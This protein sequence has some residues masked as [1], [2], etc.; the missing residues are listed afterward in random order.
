MD[1]QYSDFFRVCQDYS[2]V[3]KSKNSTSVELLFLQFLS[4]YVKT[5]NSKQF[6]VSIQTRMPVVKTDK[7]WHSRKLLVEDPTDIKRS[8]CQT[9]QSPRSSDYFRDVFNAA[10]NYFARQQKPRKPKVD[11]TVS[12]PADE[13]FIEIVTDEPKHEPKNS[14]HNSYRLFYKRLPASVARE[15]TIKQIRVRDHYKQTFDEKDNPLPQGVLRIDSS[16]DT[17]ADFVAEEIREAL[18]H[19]EET[20]FETSDANEE[21]IQGLTE[22]MSIND[23]EISS[24]ELFPEE[25]EEQQEPVIESPP[26][27]TPKEEN[28]KTAEETPTEYFYDFQPENFHAEQGAPFVCLTCNGI[29]HL[30]TECP[31]LV[32]PKMDALPKLSDEWAKILTVVCQQIT[33][34]IPLPLHRTELSV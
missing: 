11:G 19:D 17:L 31:E 30:K 25:D 1:N 32:V 22:E 33:G 23:E 12:T 34:K 27:P 16:N 7:N 5:F 14:L 3:W 20:N 4:Y 10:L 9:M 24:R 29:G 18:Q 8:L 21:Q 28:G 13:D 6:V 26:T 2:R 15:M